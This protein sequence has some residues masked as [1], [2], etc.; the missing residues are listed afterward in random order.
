MSNPPSK[1]IHADKA[2]KICQKG[3]HLFKVRTKVDGRLVAGC[4]RVE[5]LIFT[6]YPKS[7]RMNFPGS[8]RH[9]EALGF[10]YGVKTVPLGNASVQLKLKTQPRAID[11]K[12]VYDS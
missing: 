2:L 8:T 7:R 5:F 1:A 6:L 4:P 9:R 3:K 11:P 10:E 12:C